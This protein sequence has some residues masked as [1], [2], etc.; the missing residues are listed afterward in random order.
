MNLDLIKDA[1]IEDLFD[2]AWPKMAEGFGFSE[3]DSDFNMIPNTKE[4][5]RILKVGNVKY[6]ECG[7]WIVLIKSNIGY[8][9]YDR[10]NSVM[11]AL[12]K[13]NLFPQVGRGISYMHDYF[14]IV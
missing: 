12:E 13:S 7:L 14:E 8:I 11:D 3:F 6:H 5:R 2:E 10:I 9:M 4:A 1:A